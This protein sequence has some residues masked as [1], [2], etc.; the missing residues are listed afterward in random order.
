MQGARRRLTPRRRAALSL[1]LCLTAL[2]VVAIP[3]EA[4]APEPPSGLPARAWVLV[5]ADDGEVLAAHKAS[6]S[7]AI[8]STTKLMTAYVS[9]REPQQRLGGERVIGRRD[10]LVMKAELAPGIQLVL[11]RVDDEAD[12]GLRR[13]ARARPS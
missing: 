9:R 2:A 13:P 8:A 4:A 1:T 11:D 7:Y 10:D 5:D 6:S 12:D 3:A